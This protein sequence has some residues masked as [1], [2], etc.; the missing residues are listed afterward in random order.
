MRARGRAQAGPAAPDDLDGLVRVF[1][2]E[3]VR[4]LLPPL[5]ARRIAVDAQAEI[6]LVARVDLACNE[7]A[8]RAV[9]E[10]QECGAVVVELTIRDDAAQ[11]RAELGR[12]QP[13]DELGEM[14]SVHADVAHAGAQARALRV[15]APDGLLLAAALDGLGEP[16]LGVL[17]EHFAHGA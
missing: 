16:T 6:V 13:R 7:H 15:E 17:D 10:A 2:H 8:A 11:I 9:V 1:L 4:F 5:E 12:A 14:E 3:R